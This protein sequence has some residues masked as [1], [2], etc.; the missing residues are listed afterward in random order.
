MDTLF[1][2]NNAIRL[3]IVE[4]TNTYAQE[5]VKNG[6]APQGTLI[7][8]E[9]QILGR[10]QRGK[11]WQSEAGKNLTFSLILYP[12]SLLAENQF[13]LT[14]VVSLALTDFIDAESGSQVSRIKWPND[15][16]VG[17]KKIAGILIE[18][19]LRGSDIAVSIIGIGLNVNQETFAISN[20][21]SL[22]IITQKDFDLQK[23]LASLCSFIEVRYLQLVNKSDA[24]LKSAYHNKLFRLN[25]LAYY[26]IE[27]KLVE[28]KIIGVEAN[29]KL[30]LSL[31]K[32]FSVLELG[33]KE[34]EFVI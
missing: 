4:S 2:G 24:V 17:N 22:K 33:N 21:K 9:K 19:N 16:Y 32:D 28:G 6:F 18:N 25:E 1:V 5:L 31:T 10:G 15:I 13:L 29:G 30:L 34:V 23:C 8:A 20:A 26:K 11:T 7:I 12:S 27:D 3:P 14:Q